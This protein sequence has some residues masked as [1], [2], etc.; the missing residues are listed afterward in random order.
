M[1]TTKGF[2]DVL[3]MARGDRKEIHNY[4]WRK[5]KPLVPRY[6]RLGVSERT[7]FQGQII[8]EL[9]ED[10]VKDI[11]QKFKQNGVEAIAVS[12]LH[13]YT[14]PEN[15]QKI[16]KIIKASWPE[17]TISLSHQIAREYREYERTSTTAIDAYTKKKIVQYLGL[18][19]DRFKNRGFNGQA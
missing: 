15:E 14:N 2:A 6:L 8:E 19:S 12:L 17:V 11:V 1:I 3:E 7:D 4:L 9:N 10:E 18:L 5:P 16:E 13:S